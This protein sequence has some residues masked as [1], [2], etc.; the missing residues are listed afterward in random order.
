MGLETKNIRNVVLLGHSGSGKT[1]LTE[2]M[3]FEAKEISRIG[4]IESKSTTSDFTNIEKEKQNSIF[5]SIMHAGWKDSKINLIDTPGLDDFVGEVISSMK[6]A[7]TAG[8]VL[9][10]TSG[11]EVGTDLVW[12]YIEKFKTPAFFVINQLDHDKSDYEKT[13]E[14]AKERFGANVIPLQFPYNEGKGFNKI[15][16]ALRMVMYVFPENGGKPSKQEIPS[17]VLGKAQEIHN[18]I[19]E[20]AAEEDESLMEKF[21][22]EGSLSEEELANG[23]KIAL[24]NQ[25]FFPVFCSSAKNNMGA[26]RIMGFIND[27]APSP[28]DR[29]AAEL[30]GGK[31][32]PCNMNGQTSLF[33]FKTMSEPQVG[34]VSYFKV[35]SGKVKVGDDLTNQNNR[36][37][38]R[39][40][41]LF[42]TNGKN[43]QPADEIVAGDLG[44]SLKLKNSH[45]NNTISEKGLDIVI[46]P[47]HF[48][49]PRI[50]EAIVPPGKAEMEKLMKTL[51]QIEEEDPTF[52]VEQ[53]PTL[54]QTILH[55]QGQL[56][57]DIIKYRVEL[58]Q[59]ISMEFTKPKVPYRE[60][61]T[62]SSQGSY[63][64]KKQTGGAGQFGEV[65]MRIE[66]FYENMPNPSD[67]TVR[68][69]ELDDLSWGGKL[70]FLW[71]IVGGAIDK[72]Y[73]S[74]IKKGILMKMEEG[75]L[76]GS[77]VQD[78]RVSVYDGKM[79]A[80]DSSDMAF[81]IAA[82]YCFKDLFI[83]SAP[84]LL[85]PIY[86]VSILTPEESMGDIM[87]DLQTR[88]AIILG[89]DSEGHYQ[90]VIAKIPLAELYRYSSTLRS[91]SQGRSKYTMKFSEYAPVPMDLQQHLINEYKAQEEEEK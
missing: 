39:F 78:I 58:A 85:E 25:D 7:D 79:H 57:M 9:N 61:I 69:T 66:P 8:I 60:T 83:Q 46:D 86:E 45:T 84:K 23:L 64:H 12:E 65:H 13:L 42:T 90:K 88:R 50:R 49:E 16:D 51:H 22:E 82:Q 3:L 77:N 81:M 62:K 18:L 72:N 67:L 14:Q 52:I 73:S 43:R 10:A 11:V 28:A 70:S 4:T 34:L 53:N 20:K 71:C 87:G 59:G 30:E 17:D 91:L 37:V 1:M 24:I 33:I 48:P 5:S 56:H 38:E 44:V 47:I 35:Y 21:F 75:P 89:M 36:T 74:A 2:A 80:V 76:T 41:Q 6:V 54:K 15:V 29:P 55:G 40:N 63:R 68:N 19:V 32:L 31:T 27:I 26:G